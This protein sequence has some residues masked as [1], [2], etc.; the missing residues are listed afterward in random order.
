MT[1][2]ARSRSCGDVRV[3]DGILCHH[4]GVGGSGGT[5]GMAAR[6]SI[7]TDQRVSRCPHDPAGCFECKASGCR[8][9]GIMTR[10][11]RSASNRDMDGCV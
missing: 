8:G 11:A 9:G 2:V 6:A 1:G 4:T 3:D 7:A 5:L 10:L